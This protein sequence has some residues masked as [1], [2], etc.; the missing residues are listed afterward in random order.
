MSLMKWDGIFP[1]S[2]PKVHKMILLPTTNNQPLLASILLKSLGASNMY[3]KNLWRSII[4]IVLTFT[5]LLGTFTDHVMAANEPKSSG[6]DIQE[7][8]TPLGENEGKQSTSK[9]LPSLQLGDGAS[10][11][12][13][14]AV[15]LL[16]KHLA[17]LGQLE[18]DSVN[19]E[20][21]DKTE[22][23]V[24]NYQ[25]VRSITPDGKVDKN[26]W[27]KL[28]DDILSMSALN[29]TSKN[30]QHTLSGDRNIADFDP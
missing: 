23:A 22:E 3:I 12:S 29:G 6:S 18:K 28:G 7:L 19:G 4:L 15:F 11:G 2:I 26:T 5:L 14:Y 24:K 17:G 1:I 20:F 13:Q 10:N 21:S 27:S 16:Q 9:N 25:K 8:N 30:D